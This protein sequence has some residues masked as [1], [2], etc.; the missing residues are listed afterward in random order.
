MLKVELISAAGCRKCSHARDELKSVAAEIA[1]DQLRWR[2]INVL[3]ELDYAVSL[4]VLTLPAIAINGK[5]AF[6]SL[7]T[8]DQ[9]RAEI[10]RHLQQ[11]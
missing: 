5:L 10:G 3:D 7:P 1:K 8:P 2:D 11:I 6:S 4:G 9:L